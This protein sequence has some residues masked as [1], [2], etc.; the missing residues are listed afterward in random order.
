MKEAQKHQKEVRDQ[1]AID[2]QKLKEEK[3]QIVFQLEADRQMLELHQSLDNLALN[4]E[5]ERMLER[6][7]EGA[8]KTREQAR[9]SKIAYET[10]AQAADNRL[11]NAE[12][13]REAQRIID[14]LKRQRGTK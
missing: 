5:S 9:G 1:A 4:T 8:K 3:E 11:K 14:E 10:S 7:R 6:V 2:L 12:Q 13:N